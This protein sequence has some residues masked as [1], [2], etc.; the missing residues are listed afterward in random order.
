MKKKYYKEKNVITAYHS[1]FSFSLFQAYSHSIYRDLNRNFFLLDVLL[2]VFILNYE[3]GKEYYFEL[4]FHVL[5]WTYPYSPHG[6]YYFR[7]VI[8][9]RHFLKPNQLE[10]KKIKLDFFLFLVNKKFRRNCNK[11]LT[12]TTRMR[13]SREFLF[14]EGCWAQWCIIYKNLFFKIVNGIAFYCKKHLAWNKILR[15]LI[16]Y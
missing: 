14:F 12:T 10:N 3:M 9:T 15:S 5:K 8:W 11:I 4:F 7:S 6:L 16:Y 2:F 1:H 13:I